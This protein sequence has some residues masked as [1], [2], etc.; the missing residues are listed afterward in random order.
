MERPRE[1]LPLELM[2]MIVRIDLDD[3]SEAVAEDYRVGARAAGLRRRQTDLRTVSRTF[4]RIVDVATADWAFI[5]DTDTL[6]E[7]LGRLSNPQTKDRCTSVR[8]LYVEYTKRAD[9]PWTHAEMRA[10]AAKVIEACSYLSSLYYGVPGNLM[11]IEGNTFRKG[12]ILQVLFKLPALT[13]FVSASVAVTP[14]QRTIRQL[15]PNLR[16]FRCGW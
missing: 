7:I 15:L 12:P 8:H 13:S 5:L 9:D 14:A 6:R 2:E 4:N 16:R 11:I 10:A 1:I 3:A